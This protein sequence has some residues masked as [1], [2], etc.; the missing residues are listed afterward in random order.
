MLLAAALSSAMLIVLLFFAYER[1]LRS[2]RERVAEQV[3]LLLHAALENAM[4]KRDVPGLAVIVDSLGRQPGVER[5]LILEP[6]GEVRFA[7]DPLRLGTN[8]QIGKDLLPGTVNA[9]FMT[10]DNGVELLRSVNVV[11]NREPCEVCH[12]SVAVKAVNG[13]LVVDYA[14]AEVRAKAQAGAFAITLSGALVLLLTLG[15][16]WF[17]FDRR[18][19]EP[20]A[21]LAS[22]AEAWE[23]GRLDQRVAWVSSDEIGLLV[24]RCNSMATRID[25]LVK[26]IEGQ[27]LF[28]QEVLDGLPDGV[29]LIRQDNYEVV[30]ANKAF[31]KQTELGLSE[32]VRQPCYKSSHRREHPCVSSM[33][34][35]PVKELYEGEDPIITRHHHVRPDGTEYVV[36]LSAVPVM[37]ELHNHRER[38]VLESI[39][40]LMQSVRVSQEQRLSELG[41]LAAGIAH[42]IHN[43]LASIRLGVQGLVRD[44]TSENV[45]LDEI[46]EYMRVFD[47]EIDVCVDVTKRLLLL[48]RKPSEQLQPVDCVAALRD[49]FSLLSYDAHLKSI[50]HEYEGCQQPTLVYADDSDL[51]MALLNLVQNAHHAIVGSG[52]V[53]GRVKQEPD[54]VVIEVVDSGVGV[55]E[56]LRGRIF[57]PFFSRRAQGSAGTGLGLT[58]VVSVAERMGARIELDSAPGKGSCFRLI[59]PCLLNGLEETDPDR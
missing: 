13:V 24:S 59:I 40:D 33:V 53:T 26:D 23:N 34:V 29:R 54:C 31:C 46:R 7:S 42:E 1:E 5:V 12:G 8:M 14:A 9:A 56:E 28:L 50:V 2:E 15:I 57:E 47:H 45:N 4:L 11:A 55:P 44:L 20:L 17:L 19:L 10:D 16:L 43:P 6:G 25:A 52:V 27:R 48:A 37:L 30:L 49:T 32:I 21:R 51:R 38:Y 22:S 39:R 36:E 18:I 41:L 58:I 35:C 3:I